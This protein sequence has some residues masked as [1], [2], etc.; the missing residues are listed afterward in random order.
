MKLTKIEYATSSYSS[1][2][3]PTSSSNSTTLNADYE[4]SIYCLSTFNARET[5]SKYKITDELIERVAKKV[6]DLDI[7]GQI[8]ARMK[9]AP[10]PEMLPMMGGYTNES[11]SITVNGC[12]MTSN[13]VT[14]EMRAVIRMIHD[15]IP[16]CEVIIDNLVIDKNSMFDDRS[17]PQPFGFINMSPPTSQTEIKAEDDTPSD[18]EWECKCCGY[19]H[20]TGK[21]CVECGALKP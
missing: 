2:N 6:E 16:E 12:T 13:K 8:A 21:F 9:A 15:L 20:N 5:T 14:E 19:K 11:F 3:P 10:E 4:K 17:A 1:C 7:I 18:G